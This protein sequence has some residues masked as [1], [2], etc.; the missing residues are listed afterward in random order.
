MI[1]LGTL[2]GQSSEAR[3]FNDLGQVVGLSDTS[4]GETHAFLWTAQDGMIDLGTLGG[5]TSEARDVNEF[6][7]VVGSSVN[8]TGN[9][10]PFLWTPENGMIDL[11]TL[12]G[13][14]ALPSALNDTGQVVGA[15]EFDL[16][17]GDTHAFLAKVP[18]LQ[19]IND[20]IQQIIDIVDNLVITGELGQGQG[21]SLITP[22]EAA[23]TAYNA[24]HPE[25]TINS[26]QAFINKVQAFINAGHL[27]EE[28]GQPLIN[29]ANTIINQF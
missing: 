22:L 18:P 3:G 9:V 19:L 20:Q 21:K 24:E 4:S 28:D 5:I 16:Q 10:H 6:G 2:G 26:L 27:S 8:S 15:S 11:G 13:H 1:D 29:D 7:Q 12:G 25:K 17:S 14:N 23:M